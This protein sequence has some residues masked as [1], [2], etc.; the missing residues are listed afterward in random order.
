MSNQIL[1]GTMTR[2]TALKIL[3]QPPYDPDQ[4]EQDK[5]YIAKKLGI[6]VK[7]FDRMIAK[8]KK[9]PADYKNEMW[10]MKLGV[11]LSRITGMENRNLRV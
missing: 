10:L 7:E 4:M 1:A 5:E 9:T 3:K 8:P 11:A 6:T 2:E